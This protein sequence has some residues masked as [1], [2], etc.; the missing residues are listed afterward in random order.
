M[1]C[2]KRTT[3]KYSACK[4]YI[5]DYWKEITYKTSKDRGLLI[6]LP[7][8]YVSPSTGEFEN[9]M[10]YWDSY[11]INLGLLSIGKVKLAKGI[12]DNLLYEFRRFKFIPASNRFYYLAKSNPPFLSSAVLDVF[13][14]TNDRRW[15]QGA[16]KLVE[17]EYEKVWVSSQR[18]TRNGLS[19]YW[20]PTHFH[21]QAEDESG[22]D[23]TSR[24]LDRCLDINPVDLNSLLYKYE[25][26]LASM[27][28]FLGK[29]SKSKSWLKKALKRRKLINKYMWDKNKKFYFDYDYV[30]K[31][32]V[33]VYS[34]A[35]YFP[36]WAGVANEKQAESLIK[37]LRLFEK[38]GGLATT[39][40][41]YLDKEYRQ[42]DY[43]N[44]W[45]NLHWIVIKG[46]LDY[47]Y[48]NDAERIAKKWL[49]MCEKVFNQTGKFWEKYN[50]VKRSAGK[51]ERYPAQT[52]FGWTNGVFL[53][54]LDEFDQ[55]Y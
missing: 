19:R 6:G 9:K 4:K 55:G 30:S 50:V 41:S 47:G 22:W 33:F 54:L 48:Q 26:D 16:V 23:K 27:Y 49:D 12:V 44:G 35:G 2:G 10:Y 32:K 51:T 52:G 8:K 31:K 46:L 39:D 15:L 28:K 5:N 40:K 3:K 21:E 24:F 1:K 11:F 42:W 34:L 17:G 25:V 29:G 53:K 18:L 13:S 45:P 20:D 36:L 14:K 7:N 37:K 43:P 38:A